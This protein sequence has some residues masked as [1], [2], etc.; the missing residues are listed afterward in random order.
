MKNLTFL[1]LYLTSFT[2]V[3]QATIQGKIVLANSLEPLPFATV[4]LGKSGTISDENGNFSIKS[5]EKVNYFQV[6]YLGFKQQQ[7]LIKEFLTYPV[8]EMEMKAQELDEVV[9]GNGADTIIRQVI[10][11][12]GI[13]YAEKPY[14][15]MGT[16]LE[17]SKVGN[18]TNYYLNATMQGIILSTLKKQKHQIE[19][20]DIKWIEK[21]SMRKGDYM[22]WVGTGKLIEYFD[23]ARVG[24]EIL[25]STQLKKFKFI[26]EECYWNEEPCFKL[27]CYRKKISK[28]AAEVTFYILKTSYAIAAFQFI[29]AEKSKNPGEGFVS[30][31]RI[32][33]KWYL[34][35]IKTLQRNNSDHSSIMVSFKTK[36]VDT[37]ATF[38]IDY[39]RAIQGKDVMLLSKQMRFY[40]NDP[41][42]KKEYAIDSKP[43]FKPNFLK[44]FFY[45][46]IRLMIGIGGPTFT[47]PEHIF[48]EPIQSDFLRINQAF[49]ARIPSTFP[50]LLFTGSRIN[51]KG[52]WYF[53]F[54]NS[55]NFRL[56][57]SLYSSLAVGPGVE[58]ISKKRVRP[59]GLYINGRYGS[60]VDLSP[61][62]ELTLDQSQ[63]R[64]LDFNGTKTTT[65]LAYSK[66]YVSIGIGAFWELNRRRKI[67]LEMRMNRSIKDSRYTQLED[68][69]RFSFFKKDFKIPLERLEIGESNAFNIIL[70]IM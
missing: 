37:N 38:N 10:Q 26:V 45:D 61:I 67:G 42:S 6:S 20:L 44:V 70:K 21:D 15:V 57:G 14:S 17:E 30:Y 29:Q 7:V 52:P 18:N 28:S 4:I 47:S 60:Q 39:G 54:E 23:L 36:T 22:V 46:R 43:R 31:Q 24:S 27:T 9:V 3:S 12:F 51:V 69:T 11:H 65:Y 41:N 25:D 33:Q 40:R 49:H 34:N 5:N 68:P 32:N 16:Q 55:Q 56:G 48:Q 53:E 62:G 64:L 13:N 19:I 59:R 1:F 35:E 63:M 50:I 2:C 8:V 58:V 66:S